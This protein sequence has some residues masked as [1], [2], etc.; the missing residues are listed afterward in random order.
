MRESGKGETID[1]L[2]A[3]DRTW[4]LLVAAD[5]TLEQRSVA[6]VADRRRSAAVKLTVHVDGGAR[7]NP[8]PAAIAAVITD[9]DGEVLHEASE[10]I[11][12]GDEQRRRVPGAAAR[13]RARGRCS[14][15][16]SS[17][18]SATPS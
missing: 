17:T 1:Q 11:G 6:P 9:A 5:G 16:T 7:G 14:G 4:N 18:W 10:T 13:D 8:G 2:R 15:P 12:R 3:A